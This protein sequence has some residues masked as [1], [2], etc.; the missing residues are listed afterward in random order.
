M[1]RNG[2]PRHAGREVF[3]IGSAWSD[4]SLLLFNAPHPR[5][6]ASPPIAP[7]EVLAALSR[8][9]Q[10]WARYREEVRPIIDAVRREG[11]RALRRFTRQFDGVDLPSPAVPRDELSAGAGIAARGP[12]WQPG[13]GPRQHHAIPRKTAVC[14]RN[15]STRGPA[16]PAAREVRPIPSAG[17]YVPGGTAPLVSTVLMLGIPAKL[18]G[19]G[20]IVLCTPPGRDGKIAGPILAACS[21]LGIEEVFA[22]RRRPGHRRDGLRHRKR[23]EG[24]EN[25]RAGERLRR[26]GEGR[27]ERRSRTARPSTCWPGR[28]N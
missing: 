13:G 25:R 24:G 17:L 19:V 14:R 20:R 11:D 9:A 12:A 28:R 10:D 22:G 1:R 4:A 27:G 7:A 2:H 8:P 23:A 6:H 16:F 21:L 3:A 18:A 15:R 5:S 26:G